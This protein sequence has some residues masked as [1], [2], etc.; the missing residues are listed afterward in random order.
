MNFFDAALEAERATAVA[1][2]T[3]AAALRP[4][5]SAG[6]LPPIFSGLGRVPKRRSAS[7]SLLATK[8]AALPEA[9]A[10]GFVLEL[11]RAQVAAILGHT[12]AQ[13][14]EPTTAF[15]DLCFYSPAAAKLRNR[16]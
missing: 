2:P 5:A 4:L 6:V 7:S 16:V 10:A 11:V 9:E 12:S 3:K 14:V 1:F 15:P 13:D 8:L